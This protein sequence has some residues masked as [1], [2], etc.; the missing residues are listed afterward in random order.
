MKF[1]STNFNK[2]VEIYQ[3]CMM[4]KL[5][6][7]ALLG[8][9]AIGISACETIPYQTRLDNF[10]GPIKAKYIGQSVDNVVLD[11]GPP[12]SSYTLSDGREIIQ[13]SSRRTDRSSAGGTIALGTSF[14]HYYNRGSVLMAWPMFSPY[15]NDGYSERELVCIKRFMVNKDKKVE[16]FRWE[17]NSCF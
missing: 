3:R 16:D 13:Y 6:G 11:M 7:G 12:S 10:E 14:G 4:K 2:G 15:Y 9:F 8:L 5:L 1:N 17:G